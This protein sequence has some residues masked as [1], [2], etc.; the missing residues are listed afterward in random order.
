MKVL[1][2]EAEVT[3]NPSVAFQN[4]INF[5]AV[6]QLVTCW[7]ESLKK[8]QIKHLPQLKYVQTNQ[9]KIIIKKELWIYTVKYYKNS[10]LQDNHIKQ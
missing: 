1:D 3:P 4:I 6:I 10:N 5:Y 7:F 9:K 8:I 2:S